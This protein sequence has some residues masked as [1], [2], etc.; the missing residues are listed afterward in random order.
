MAVKFLDLRNN[1]WYVEY[2]DGTQEPCH[3]RATAD[4]L[5]RDANDNYEGYSRAHAVHYLPHLELV[6]AS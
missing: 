2:A 1:Q 4:W 3:N 5:V 6:E